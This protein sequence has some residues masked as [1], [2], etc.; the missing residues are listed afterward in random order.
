MGAS[1]MFLLTWPFLFPF[2]QGYRK[3]LTNALQVL[4]SSKTWVGYCTG[5]DLS[6]LPPL[7]KSIFDPSA[8]IIEPDKDLKE[9]LNMEYARNYRILIDF[10]IFRR[11]IF[12]I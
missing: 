9:K 10:S 7:K 1:L 6:G 11:N 4:S 3:N 2:I 12:R 5:T 8:G